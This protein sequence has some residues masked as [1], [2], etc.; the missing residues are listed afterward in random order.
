MTSVL[1][2][3]EHHHLKVLI[4]NFHLSGHT[5]RFHWMVQDLEV[6]M[7]HSNSPLAVKGF[8][9]LS[10]RLSTV[11]YQYQ[12]DRDLPADSHSSLHTL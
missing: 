9:C 8:N 12:V 7:V 6:F 3:H 4:K 10:I 5:F 11:T 2:Q 1:Q